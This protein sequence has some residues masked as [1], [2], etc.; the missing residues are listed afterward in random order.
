MKFLRRLENGTIVTTEDTKGM[1]L[2]EI[3]KKYS[4][5]PCSEIKW[6]HAA[7]NTT[8]SPYLPGFTLTV[9]GRIMTFA[10]DTGCSS[11]LVTSKLAKI[12]PEEYKGEET[13]LSKEN[14]VMNTLGGNTPDAFGKA[15]DLEIPSDVSNV[16]LYDRF[17]VAPAFQ[18]DVELKGYAYDFLLGT[19]FLMKHYVVID[20]GRKI[21]SFAAQSLNEFEKDRQTRREQTSVPAKRFDE[22]IPLKA[23]DIRELR[24]LFNKND[25]ELEQAIEQ[26]TETDNGDA[27]QS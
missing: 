13:M 7:F 9:F 22:S 15:L 5:F 20:Y 4:E 11:N 6:R 14:R 3:I 12:W 19:P 2:Q 10:I 24:I 18:K 25:A 16:Y 26:Q 27:K 23:E 21:I 8:A 17:I 1:S